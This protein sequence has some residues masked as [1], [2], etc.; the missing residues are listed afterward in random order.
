MGSSAEIV[1]TPGYGGV[2]KP[3]AGYN[4]NSHVSFWNSETLVR[5]ASLDC[6]TKARIMYGTASPAGHES[7]V[8]GFAERLQIW[9]CMKKKATGLRGSSTTMSQPFSCMIR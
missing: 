4:E 3:T 5:T 2:S 7:L 1:S 6:R 9:N 8:L